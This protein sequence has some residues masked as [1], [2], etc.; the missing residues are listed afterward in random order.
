VAGILAGAGT[1][2]MHEILSNLL[3]DTVRHYRSQNGQKKNRK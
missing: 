3:Y 1:Q 2:W